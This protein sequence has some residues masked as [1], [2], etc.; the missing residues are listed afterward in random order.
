MFLVI[1]DI[2][3]QDQAHILLRRSDNST[4]PATTTIYWKSGKEKGYFQL[5]DPSPI[6]QYE[7]ALNLYSALLKKY[8]LEIQ[9]PGEE[10]TPL[11]PDQEDQQ[12][13]LLSMQ[14]YLRLTEYKDIDQSLMSQ[15]SL[16]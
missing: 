14:D 10:K 15:N 3:M 13:Y 7:F 2:W 1:A 4:L 6:S 16:E 8:Q 9:F 12:N 5:E 11:F